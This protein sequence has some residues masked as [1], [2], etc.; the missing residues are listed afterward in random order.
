VVNSI[1]QPS[2]LVLGYIYRPYSAHSTVISLLYS[3]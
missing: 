1:A 2:S 3:F